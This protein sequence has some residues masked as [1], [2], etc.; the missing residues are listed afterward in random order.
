MKILSVIVLLCLA[1]CAQA[2]LYFGPPDGENI[3]DVADQ[4]GYLFKVEKGIYIQTDSEEFLL[5]IST[6]FENLKH[7]RTGKA[8]IKQVSHYH[9]LSLPH[10]PKIFLLK[11]NFL[12]N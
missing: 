4:G 6:L 2:S 1:T 7:T 9:P 3:I 5:G 8:I 11:R 12:S 10:K